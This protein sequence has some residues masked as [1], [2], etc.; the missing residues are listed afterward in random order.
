MTVIVAVGCADVNK[1]KPPEAASANPDR[2]RQEGLSF[3]PTSGAGVDIRAVSPQG[4]LWV[5][6]IHG[7]AFSSRPDPFALEPK[8]RQFDVA[9]STERIF[10]QNNFYSPSFVPVDDTVPQPEIEPQPY[11]RLAGVIVGDSILAL[12]DM[13]NGQLQI[14]RPGQDI[15]GW[16]VDSINSEEAVLSR[17]G[18]LLP[19][20]IHVRLEE[21]PPGSAGSGGA[22]GGGGA[23]VAPGGSG[24]QVG[25]GGLVGK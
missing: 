23:G 24:G 5:T 25:Q 21:P 13:G 2:V 19:H 3:H 16:H 15:D 9:Q 8:E 22:G 1:L 7:L 18:N 6:L 10:S 20:T 17:H 12:I 14:I 11:R 4:Q